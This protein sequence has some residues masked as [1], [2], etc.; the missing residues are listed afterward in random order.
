MTHSH[1]A[2]TTHSH[3]HSLAVSRITNHAANQPTDPR[4][5]QHIPARQHL[6]ALTGN[7]WTVSTTMIH[8][9][10]HNSALP[11]QR[12]NHLPVPPAA[13]S[14]VNVCWHKLR[15]QHFR[16]EISKLVCEHEQ[17]TT[18]LRVSWTWGPSG[19]M[20]LMRGGNMATVSRLLQVQLERTLANWRVM[21]LVYRTERTAE[22][23]IIIKKQKETALKEPPSMRHE[24]QLYTM[25]RHSHGLQLWRHC[26]CN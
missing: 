4:V 8:Q 25:W 23:I 19:L 12:Y 9:H 11:R 26:Q 10:G 21:S 1:T 13:S 16:R 22:K 14:S 7:Y 20:I 17:A 5:C 18:R 2:H 15:H 6:I 24:K 3:S